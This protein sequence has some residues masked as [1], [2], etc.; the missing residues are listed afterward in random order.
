MNMHGRARIQSDFTN[1][2]P[3][4]A[5]LPFTVE[6]VGGHVDQ[7]PVSIPRPLACSAIN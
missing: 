1:A 6:G 5:S 3:I 4:S 2:F 7:L